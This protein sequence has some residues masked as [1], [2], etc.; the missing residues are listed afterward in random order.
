MNRV[1]LAVLG[2]L[3]IGL[4]MAGIAVARGHIDGAAIL[5]AVAIFYALAITAWASTNRKRSR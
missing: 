2:L 4:L 3:G 1:G 5:A